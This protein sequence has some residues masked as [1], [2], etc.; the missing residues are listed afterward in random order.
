MSSFNCRVGLSAILV[1]LVLVNV[2]LGD[3][4]V[5]LSSI[6]KSSPVSLGNGDYTL[7]SHGDCELY[8]QHAGAHSTAEWKITPMVDSNRKD[9]WPSESKGF[10]ITEIALARWSRSSLL[11]VVKVSDGREAKF[12]CLSFKHL[13]KLLQES[14]QVTAPAVVVTSGNTKERI[15]A[16]SGSV[17]SPAIT[18][19]TGTLS[20][21]SPGTID[22]GTIVFEW[23]GFPEVASAGRF[24]PEYLAVPK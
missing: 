5:Q 6:V 11:A 1:L 22:R 13:S 2:G 12:W 8:L 14:N 17:D 20:E 15:L 18:I 7:V 4:A 23:C 3:P 21:S 9:V 24:K 19:V 16:V 10:Q